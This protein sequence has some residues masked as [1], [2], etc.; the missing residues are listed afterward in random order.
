MVRRDNVRSDASVHHS[1]VEA[2]LRGQREAEHVLDLREGEDDGVGEAVIQV[3]M[4]QQ[5]RAGERRA[6]AAI[7]GGSG[8]TRAAAPAPPAAA[9]SAIRACQPALSDTTASVVS[10]SEAIDAAF[11]SADR[12]T[13]VGSMTP[14]VTRFS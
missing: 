10:S 2:R 9:L 13:L 3:G 14:A 1:G 6:A 4:Q 7:G 12:T 11:C 5:I 8:L